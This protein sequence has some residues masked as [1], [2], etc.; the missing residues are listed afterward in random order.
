MDADSNV[1]RY[2]LV[3]PSQHELAASLSRFDLD[4]GLVDEVLYR[5]CRD[6]PSHTDRRAVTA[7][8]ALIGRVYAAGLERRVTPPPGQQAIVVIA[9]YV[10]EHGSEVDEIVRAL[11]AV[12][13]PLDSLSM[14]S[15]VEQHGRLTRLL[16]KVATDDKAP[17]SFTSKYLH[18]H[19]PVVPIYD[20]Y[21]RQALSRLVHWQSSYAPFALP[22]HG[23]REYWDYCLRFFRL[24]DACRQAGARPTVKELDAYLWAVPIAAAGA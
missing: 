4:W 20:E 6:Y 15:I 8:L 18:F 3:V 9:D 12:R 2:S 24:Y 17:R 22:P 10:L 7:K 13:E 21:A 23:D 1:S 11:D 14:D 16:Q 5:L 19:N